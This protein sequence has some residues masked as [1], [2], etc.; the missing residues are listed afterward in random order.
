MTL[1]RLA[2]RG[3][4]CEA[5]DF[6]IDPW[7]PVE[8]AVITHA[9]GDHARWGSE[10]YLSSR[11][12]AE[13]LRTRLG[14][15]ATIRAVDYGQAIDINGVRV[16]LHPAG[17]ILGSAQIRIEH[18]GRVVVASGDYKVELDRTCAPFE[19]VRC[20]VF[21]TESTFGLPIYRWKPEAQVSSEINAWW[22]ANREAGRSSLI[23]GYA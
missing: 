22:R 11:E 23:Y 9:H 16:S 13:V 8:R 4:Y 21:L 1:L 7:Q 15:A 19:P 12:G 20:H 6:Y 3:L 5:G 14:P 18:R 17:H 2:E 10:R